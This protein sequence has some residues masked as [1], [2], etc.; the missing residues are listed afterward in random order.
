MVEKYRL[1][2]AE[3]DNRIVTLQGEN[4]KQE[5]LV[6]RCG[7][8][9]IQLEERVEDQKQNETISQLAADTRKEEHDRL[10]K[11][12]MKEEQKVATLKSDK[13]ELNR[14]IKELEDALE[15][16]EE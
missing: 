10:V 5:D 12:F 9:I 15:D 11:H 2:I 14:K 7:Q 4:K 3:R 16:K 6:Q 8:V 1:T 13:L